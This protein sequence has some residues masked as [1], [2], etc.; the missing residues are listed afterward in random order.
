MLRR[1]RRLSTRPRRCSGRSNLGV[2]C[3]CLF[4]CRRRRAP[5][6]IDSRPVQITGEIWLNS[7]DSTASA[8]PRRSRSQAR[9][10]RRRPATSRGLEVVLRRG[11][12]SS[13]VR[14]VGRRAVARDRP[15]R[16][17]VARARRRA[18]PRAVR[19]DLDEA[20]LLAADDAV[21]VNR[22][23]A[24]GLRRH[25]PRRRVI[26]ARRVDS[27]VARRVAGVVKEAFRGVVRLAA[28]HLRE[29]RARALCGFRHRCVKAARL[30]VIV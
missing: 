5:E 10:S 29:E 24:R 21:L 27:L 17:R 18:E 12:P 7:G 22:K 30:K 23:L 1:H 16:R 26:A 13:K 19:R 11:P 3:I 14:F 15:A 20:D 28:A 25:G 6:A 8:A 4:V 9:G 2:S